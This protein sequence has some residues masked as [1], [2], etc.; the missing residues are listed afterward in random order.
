MAQ[1][2]EMS[3]APNCWF[4]LAGSGKSTVQCMSTE[5]CAFCLCIE[6]SLYRLTGIFK[7]QQQKRSSYDM[8]DAESILEE[9][10]AFNQ[11]VDAC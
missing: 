6:S 1:K 9:R 10:K 8:W 4:G 5:M 11:D 7:R 3:I 2:Q